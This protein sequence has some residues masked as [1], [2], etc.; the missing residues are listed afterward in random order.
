M[1]AILVADGGLCWSDNCQGTRA[2]VA[3]G[4]LFSS[5]EYVQEHRGVRAVDRLHLAFD[6]GTVRFVK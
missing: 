6:R 2:A 3:S 5:V 4:G 1:I